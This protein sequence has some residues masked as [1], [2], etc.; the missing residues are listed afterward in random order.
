MRLQLTGPMTGMP[1]Y[2]RAAFAEAA[3]HLRAAGFTVHNPGE[4]I[5]T[6]HSWAA[7]MRISLEALFR[8]DALVAMPG[9][10]HSPGARL[11]ALVAHALDIPVIPLGQINQLGIEPWI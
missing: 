7:Y 2:N 1:N 5:H 11:E 8:A 6:D 10:Q 3:A 9:W 4:E